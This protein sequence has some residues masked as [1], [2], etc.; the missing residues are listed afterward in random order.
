M[1][2]LRKAVSL[3][4]LDL[5]TPAAR[6]RLCRREL[7]VNAPA[8][9]WLYRTVHAVRRGADG[10]LRLEPV[11]AAPFLA[12]AGGVARPDDPGDAPRPELAGGDADRAIDWVL[13]MAPLPADGF[14]DAVAARGGIDGA[15]A[16]ALGD[17]AAGLHGALPPVPGT[18]PPAA[19][20]AVLA[21]NLDAARAAGLPEAPV[22]A[23]GRTSGA[24][25]D[26]LAPVLRARAAAGRVRRCHGDLHLGN[27]VLRDGRPTAIDALEFDEALATIDTGY[28]LAFLLMDLDRRAGRAAANRALARY[29]ARTGDAGLV[30]GLPW[31]MSQRALVRAHCVARAGDPARGAALLGIAADHLRPARPGAVRLLAVGGL[32]GTGKTRL[33]RALAP[34]LGPA[35]GALLLRSDETRKRLGAVAFEARLPPDAYAGPRSAAVH[36]TLFRMAGEALLGGHAV[37]LDAAFLE[38][39]TRLAAAAVAR[40]AGVPFIGLWLEAPL[41]LL[42]ARVSARRGDASDA[43]AA[44]LDA[45]ARADPGPPDGWSRLDASDDPVP[46]ALALLAACMC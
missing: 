17:A 23:L 39:S 29:V 15:L 40:A 11:V 4:F 22:A 9:P 8:A 26:R 16:D 37:I 5:S 2:K 10:A 21:G 30:A 35:P 6:E 24:A 34:G 28:D 14:L 12:D 7:A 36:D 32:Q 33:A 3:G 20:R 41:V 46:A 43:D 42:R 45:A 1:L 27:L 44:V 25:L 38:P 18:D 13:E 31:W 19:M